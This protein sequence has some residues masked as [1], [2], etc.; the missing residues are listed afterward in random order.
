VRTPR[1]KQLQ[2][3]TGADICVSSIAGTARDRSSA[4]HPA[5]M[6]ER[7]PSAGAQRVR[8]GE[9]GVVPLRAGFKPLLEPLVIL[10]NLPGGLTPRERSDKLSESM[11]L[12]VELEAHA[13]A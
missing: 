4:L 2:V 3:S 13:R 1:G 12:Q 6:R 8:P 11:A 10:R 7:L 9:R 5:E